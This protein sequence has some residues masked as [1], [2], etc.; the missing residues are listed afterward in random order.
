MSGVVN[1]IKSV[2]SFVAPVL[3]LVQ[4]IPGVG[5]IVGVVK[6]AVSIVSNIDQAFSNFPMGLLNVA[7]KAASAFLPTPLD[8]I[9]KFLEN[10]GAGLFNL[11]PDGI[12]ALV[13]PS[14]VPYVPGVL[15][16]LIDG[17]A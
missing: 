9:G 13:P 10:P 14:F 8:Q 15:N 16:D 6:S 3:D 2:A 4:M 7:A 17:W 11:L 12:K 1:A 5:Q